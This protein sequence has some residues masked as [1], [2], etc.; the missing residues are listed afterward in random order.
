MS[1]IGPRPLRY[2]YKEI[3]NKFQNKRHDVYPGITGWA[4]I[5]GRNS[6]SWDQKFIYDIFNLK[7]LSINEWYKNFFCPITPAKTQMILNKIH[8]I[9]MNCF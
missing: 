8:N 9:H 2:E 5:N 1:F 7:N 6:I 3:Y 4:Q